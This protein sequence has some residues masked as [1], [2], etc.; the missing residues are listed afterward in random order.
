MKRE[1]E[2][3]NVTPITKQAKWHE[4]ITHFNSYSHYNNI[5]Y[6]YIYII[7]HRDTHTRTVSLKCSLTSFGAL[8]HHHHHT[9]LLPTHF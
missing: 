2:G 8:P 1:G 7:E 3:E 6:I 9:L 5:I 4:S